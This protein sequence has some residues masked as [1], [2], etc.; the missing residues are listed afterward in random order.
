MEDSGE[1]GCGAGVSE[2]MGFSMSASKSEMG[3]AVGDGCLGKSEIRSCMNERCEINAKC[4]I[5]GFRAR[6]A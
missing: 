3:V 5:V 2:L 6:A 4:A 1:A